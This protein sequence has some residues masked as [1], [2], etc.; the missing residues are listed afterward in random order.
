MG[1]QVECLAD[2]LSRG[3]Y[4]GG[5]EEQPGTGQAVVPYGQSG[6]EMAGLDDGA[7]IKG[8]VNGTEA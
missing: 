2:A 6:M 3:I 8:G 4:G 1:S 7:A 5:V